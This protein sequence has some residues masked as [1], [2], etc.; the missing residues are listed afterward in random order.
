M[1]SEKLTKFSH[2][3]L[4]NNLMKDLLYDYYH[5][6]IPF[7][8]SG[9]LKSYRSKSGINPNPDFLKIGFQMVRFLKGRAL[10][11]EQ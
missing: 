1:A 11:F 6:D 7:E 3:F 10:G 2:L 4:L 8:Y 9:D 5:L